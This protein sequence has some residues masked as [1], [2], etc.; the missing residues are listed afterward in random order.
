MRILAAGSSGACARQDANNPL[1][2]QIERVARDIIA[3]SPLVSA[4]CFGRRIQIRGLS[5]RRVA[6]FFDGG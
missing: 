1:E 5:G 4:G 3:W 2:V 6:G